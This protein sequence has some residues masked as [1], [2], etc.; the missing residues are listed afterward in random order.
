MAAITKEDYLRAL[1]I[2]ASMFCVFF[3][4]YIVFP[5][6]PF[7]A[8]DFVDRPR[9]ELG[10][11]VGFLG[12]SFSLGDMFGSLIWGYVADRQGR[13]PVMI[14]TTAISIGLIIL[15]GC[16]QNFYWAVLSRF[17]WG[18][19]SSV[20]GV[21]KTILA[22]IS[23]DE[24]RTQ[25]FSL[26]MIMNGVAR[27]IGPTVGGLLYNPAEKYPGSAVDVK[28]FRTLPYLL[29]CLVSASLSV[30]NL[31][32][33][34]LFLKETLKKP[35]RATATSTK[36]DD[37]VSGVV[38]QDGIEAL[39]VDSGG[40]DCNIE[41][42]PMLPLMEQGKKEIE[43]S[44][45]IP[46]SQGHAAQI[47][48]GSAAT[49]VFAM[50]ED[51]ERLLPEQA[52]SFALR[53]RRDGHQ[54]YQ[55]L[56]ETGVL[57]SAKKRN[58]FGCLGYVKRY[59]SA[60]RL[61]RDQKIR[62]AILSYVILALISIVHTETI[63]LLVI[64]DHK[65]G[66]LCFNSSEIGIVYGAVGVVQL[67]TQLAIYPVTARRFGLRGVY[68]RGV[69]LFS[70]IFVLFPWTSTIF[71]SLDPTVLPY[72]GPPSENHTTDMPQVP[73]Q[74][75]NSTLSPI[76]SIENLTFSDVWPWGTIPQAFNS[77]EQPL[78]YETNISSPQFTYPPTTRR[79]I[80]GSDSYDKPS[81]TAPQP[82]NDTCIIY[83]HENE[84][85]SDE[86]SA[87]VRSSDDNETS[88]AGA[89]SQIGCIPWWVWPALSLI[90]AA[91]SNTL[92]FAFTS[93]IIMVNNSCAADIR[94]RVNGI[95]QQLAAIV[96][97]LGPM[98]GIVF[99]ASAS[100]D[101]PF[102]LNYHLTF[103]LTSL[104]GVGAV[105]FSRRLPESI[106]R[107]SVSTDGSAENSLAQVEEN[108]LSCHDEEDESA[109]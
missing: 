61:L 76:T 77:T 62:T 48:N 79:W 88:S 49:S 22:E 101:L 1:P 47:P 65:H 87:C 75:T 73:R 41:V 92:I 105:I 68:R 37:F 56:S 9:Q 70:V 30:I 12:S 28:L 36:E 11:F 42:N 5:F 91:L 58:A 32:A 34:V 19:F 78:A 35:G 67:F 18:F 55:R 43:E 50:N 90:M 72:P 71:G 89:F 7:M 15:F 95:S 4:L 44:V 109:M 14:T 107:Q 31:I 23:S 16:A 99:A 74:L 102:P 8:K 53:P 82:L 57:P 51:E 81:P 39:D 85:G 26:I 100:S 96:R 60:Y 17:T 94:S 108:S 33:S 86:I 20:T 98:I 52:G 103:W 24:N 80:Y 54:I 29:P 59:F 6:L 66:G 13:R 106:E 40:G 3:N 97:F 25:L 63:P 83:R 69:C 104:L 27:L 45:S 10:Y 21:A 46:H 84:T 38:D 2:S 64:N 93:I